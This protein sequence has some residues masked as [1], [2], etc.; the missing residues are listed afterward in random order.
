MLYPPGTRYNIEKEAQHAPIQKKNIFLNEK[1][2]SQTN[3]K[4]NRNI[5]LPNNHLLCTVLLLLPLLLLFIILLQH[6]LNDRN[7]KVNP[8]TQTTGKKKILLK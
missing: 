3:K 2:T 6:I 1:K 7:T 5:N 4:K 8:I